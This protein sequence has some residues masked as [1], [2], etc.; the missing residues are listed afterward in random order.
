MGLIQC[1][2]IRFGFNYEEFRFSFSCKTPLETWFPASCRG[3]FT[4]SSL[5]LL[6]CPAILRD[7]IQ[8]WQSR[9]E[10]RVLWSHPFLGSSM[11]E[12]IKN[13]GI[14]LL[15]KVHGS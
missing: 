4:G 5:R 11:K 1:V 2:S 8:C 13:K 6:Y 10:E 9:M 3:C 14:G 7:W 12:G 15:K